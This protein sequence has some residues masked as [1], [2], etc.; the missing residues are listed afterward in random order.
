MKQVLLGFALV[1]AS[2]A[3]SAGE[4]HRGSYEHYRNLNGHHHRHSYHH[5]THSVRHYRSSE[6]LE[7]IVGGVILGAVLYQMLQPTAYESH[8]GRV[9]QQPPQSLHEYVLDLDGHCYSVT[10][11]ADRRVLTEVLRGYCQTP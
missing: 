10:R 7:N 11:W 4:S 2:A 9:D 1:C 3:A 6:R 8:S 5:K